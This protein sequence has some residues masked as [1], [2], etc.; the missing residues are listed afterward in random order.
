MFYDWL[1]CYQDHDAKLPYI[2]ERA[3]IIID[4][5][6]GEQLTERQPT[7]KHEGS[8]STSISIRISGNRV[9]VKGNPSR[10]NR[11]DN[12]VGYSN[13]DDCIHVYNNVL[14]SLGLPPFTKCTKRIYTTSSDGKKV[15]VASDG[16]VIQELHI[17]TNK[18]VGTDNVHQ[19]IAGLSTQRYRNS[20]PRLHTNGS[21]VDW[22]SKKGNAPLVYASVYSKSD[23]LKLHQIPKI[24][25]LHGADSPEY[26]YLLK[27]L[28]LCEL[29]GVARFE[30]KLKSRYI[31]REDL[32][33]W[34]LSDYS[35]LNQLHNE[36]LNIDKS[37]QVNA[38]TFQTIADQLLDENI[39]NSRIA[40]NATANYLFMW[41][42]GQKF[43]LQKKQVKVHRARLRKLHIDIA[44][45]CDTTKFSAVR[46]QNVREIEVGELA[47]PD[48]YKQPQPNFLK[49]VA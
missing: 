33:F 18:T 17:T 13:I 48:W 20:I 39:V 22:L 47:A 44:E 5:D 41:M 11:I 25:R 4:T 40:A 32:Q 14:L 42:H 19:Y 36:F 16:A 26:A 23:E 45:K 7:L 2:G 10:Y 8:F 49:L 31:R 12:L 37:L 46:I 15:P 35:K 6:S 9:T 24:K 43:D 1:T 27:V 38:M 29:Q 28:Q 34:G 3:E 30:Q 21:T